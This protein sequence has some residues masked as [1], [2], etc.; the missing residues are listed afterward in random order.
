[1]INSRDIDA[2]RPDVAENCRILLQ[3]AAER[4]LDVL[5]TQ[6]VRDGEYQAA[7]YAQ[8]RTQPGSIVTN[9]SRPS[10]HD[11]AAGL[12]FDVCKN[13]PGHAYDDAD[14]FAQVGAL[15]RQMGFTWGGDW[16]RFPD[17]PHFQWDGRGVY[18]AAM[19]RAGNY[20]PRMPR[21]EEA[22]TVTQEQF[23]AM[24]EAYLNKLR[25]RPPAAW[26]GEARA[27]AERIGL[28][29]G[30]ETGNKQYAAFLTREQMVVLL[31]RLCEHIGHGT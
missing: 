18:S 3:R 27:W 5:V 2:L 15:G 26:S 1:M 9:A 24:M 21:F 12:A 30:D 17:R 28:I 4:G 22:E 8:G 29:R 13:A 6:T 19:V 14:F 16:Q 11:V 25:S 31:R 23:D 20:P 7:L 10:F